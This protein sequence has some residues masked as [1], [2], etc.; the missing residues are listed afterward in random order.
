MS[1]HTPGPWKVEENYHW[2]RKVNV[3][4]ATGKDI[5]FVQN[6]NEADARLIAQAPAMLEALK[7]VLDEIEKEHPT[8]DGWLSPS[9]HIDTV[10][11]IITTIRAA[12]GEE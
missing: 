4:P 5:A 1:K 10:T 9:I 12:E 3:V 11:K 6:L 7:E 2:N 8:D